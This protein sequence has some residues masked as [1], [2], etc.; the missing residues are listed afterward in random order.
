[1]WG[2]LIGRVISQEIFSVEIFLH[3]YLHSPITQELFTKRP[4]SPSQ[5]EANFPFFFIF[6]N[7]KKLREK[8]QEKK[9]KERFSIKK[10]IIYKCQMV[11]HEF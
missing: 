8:Q 11:P 4:K 6:T 10:W 9:L 2:F 3:F 7:R 1:M 5:P